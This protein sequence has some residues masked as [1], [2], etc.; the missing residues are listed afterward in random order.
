MKIKINEVT[1]HAGVYHVN[2]STEYGSAIALWNGNEPEVNKE[3]FVEV[4]VPCVLC[5]QKDIVVTD[6]P[7]VIWLKN[8]IVHIVAILESVDDDGY[9]VLRLGGSIISVMARGD[10]LSVGSKVKLTTNALALY[11]VI[12]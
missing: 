3:Y 9:A 2:F 10:S 5:W 1:N 8:N 6:E 12:F 4:E 11:E 7:C